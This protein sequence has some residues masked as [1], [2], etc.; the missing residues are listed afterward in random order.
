M[1]IGF[2]ANQNDCAIECAIAIWCKVRICGRDF[3]LLNVTQ[4]RPVI[5]AQILGMEVLA[6]I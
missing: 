3:E 1:S 4:V 2:A 5:P 6:A